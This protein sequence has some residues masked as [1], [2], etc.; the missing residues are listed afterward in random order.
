MRAAGAIPSPSCSYQD[1]L[2][3][4]GATGNGSDCLKIVQQPNATFDANSTP[5]PIPGIGSGING[6][7]GDTFILPIGRNTYR[8]PSAAILDFRLTKRIRLSDRYSFDLLGEAFNVLN[9]QNVTGLQTTGYRIV[10]DKQHANMASLIWQSG[11]KPGVTT[12]MVN[13]TSVTQPV[14]DATAAFGSPT[15]ANSRSF[16]RER[17]IQAGIRLHF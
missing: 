10:N 9:H 2:A 1:W 8:Y 13:G 15:N 7:G 14:F 16:S 4:G 17:Q 6:S 3:A 12:L 11:M 5:V